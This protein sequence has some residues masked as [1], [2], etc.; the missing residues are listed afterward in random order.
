MMQG[1]V[2]L[3]VTLITGDIMSGISI[4]VADHAANLVPDAQAAELKGE[5]SCYL[6]SQVQGSRHPNMQVGVK[7]S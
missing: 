4:Q 2:S 7:Q 6:C 1:L 3:A 5:A